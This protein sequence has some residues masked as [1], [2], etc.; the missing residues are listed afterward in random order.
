MKRKEVV[1][2]PL[3]VKYRSELIAKLK[4]AQIPEAKDVEV[5]Q[6]ENKSWLNK[7]NPF[8]KTPKA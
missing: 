7:V 8:S 5:E 1:V 3:K 6:P 4:E 2:E